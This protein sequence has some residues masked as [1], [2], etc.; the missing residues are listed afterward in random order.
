MKREYQPNP[1]IHNPLTDAFSPE[2]VFALDICEQAGLVA[3]DHFKKGIEAVNKEDG[4]P[5]TAADKEC[6]RLIREAINARFPADAILGEEEGESKGK[7]GKTKSQRKWIVDPIDGT[8]GYARGLPVFSTLLALEDSGEII[9]GVVNAPAM[10][11]LFWAEKGEALL[12]MGRGSKSLTKR[13]SANRNLA[14]AAP[15]V[16]SA[17]VYGQA[18]RN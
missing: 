14:L 11:D 13:R 9:V 5:V 12:K 4:T 2:L 17:L 16:S 18:L 15:I 7:G 8:Y 6:E 3:L 10:G 1:L